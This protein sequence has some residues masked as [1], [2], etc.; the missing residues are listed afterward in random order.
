MAQAQKRPMKFL[1]RAGRPQT[2]PWRRRRPAR[3]VVDTLEGRALQTVVPIK[4]IAVATPQIIPPTKNQYV[5]V[6]ISGQ[7]AS[8]HP[9][10]PRGF[11]HVT[12]EYRRVEPFGAV[13]LTP[14][15]A[16]SKYGIYQFDYSFTINLQAT[17]STN[18]PDGRHYN[19]LIAAEDRDTAD[20]KTITALVP[21]TYPLRPP[22]VRPHNAGPRAL[23]AKGHRVGA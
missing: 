16:D 11:F 22:V 21:K 2:S 18:T 8:T 3:P 1:P 10:V 13:K 6:V 4:F 15:L 23:A 9:E 7:V 19:I 12:D 20:G 14:N 17:R 5:P